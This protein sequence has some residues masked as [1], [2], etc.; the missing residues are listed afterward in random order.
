MGSEPEWKTQS[1]SFQKAKFCSLLWM[2]SPSTTTLSRHLRILFTQ[3]HSFLWDRSHP[4]ENLPHLCNISISAVVYFWSNFNNN[5]CS[6]IVLPLLLHWLALSPTIFIITQLRTRD[7]PIRSIVP[8]SDYALSD[9]LR[10]DTCQAK[11]RAYFC[12]QN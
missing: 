9:S 12:C 10:W 2:T 8:L 1:F 7:K 5:S 4:S 11:N 3:T 6:S